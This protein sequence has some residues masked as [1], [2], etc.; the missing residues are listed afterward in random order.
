MYGGSLAAGACM[1]LPRLS[2][3]APFRTTCVQGLAGMK[4]HRIDCP[5]VPC[6]GGE[7][8]GMKSPT[9]PHLY[10]IGGEK[11]YRGAC[12]RSTCSG[13]P[14]RVVARIIPCGLTTRGRAVADE[15]QP[16]PPLLLRES[17]EHGGMCCC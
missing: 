2:A 14:R 5:L 13:L 8:I 7:V 4:Q 11:A 12:G 1:Q 10:T 17:N 15:P 16:S 3:P 9:A 6:P